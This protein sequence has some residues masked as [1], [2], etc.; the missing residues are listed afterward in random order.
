MTLAGKTALVTGAS[1]GIGKEIA[2]ELA[3]NGA[4]IVVNYAGNT[5]L[6][7]QVADE[8]RSIGRESIAIQADVAN[9]EAVE[10]MVKETVNMFGTLDILVNNAGIT[11][12]Q[13]L[14]RMKESDWDDVLNTNLKSVFL[15]TK[16]V[17]RQMMKQRKGRIINISSIVGVSGNAGQ[18]NYVAA[19]AG[20]IG[21]TKTAAKELAPRNITVNAVAPGFITTDM[22]D[23]LPEDVKQELY[24][25]IPLARL[26]EPKDIAYVVAFLASEKSSYITGQT[27]HVNG[28]MYM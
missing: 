3:R 12:D 23:K 17:S 11:R 2:L 14:M 7:E 5:Q 1:R 16:A 28:G 20:I 27:I 18:A 10:Q 21:L 8:I 4:N 19:K 25:Q 26:G 6:A 15:T 22:T 13:L 24:K 9:S